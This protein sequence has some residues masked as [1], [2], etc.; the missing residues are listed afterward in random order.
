MYKI[1]ILSHNFYR[2][3]QGSIVEVNLQFDLEIDLKDSLHSANRKMYNIQGG[4]QNFLF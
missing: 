4:L 2:K 1:S 3:L